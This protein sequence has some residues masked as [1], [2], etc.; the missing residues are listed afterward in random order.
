MKRVADIWNASCLRPSTPYQSRAATDNLLPISLYQFMWCCTRLIGIIPWYNTTTDR[1]SNRQT[2]NSKSPTSLSANPHF[3]QIASNSFYGGSIFIVF[4]PL[5]NFLHNKGYTVLVPT[6]YSPNNHSNSA[7]SW[8]LINPHLLPF[9]HSDQTSPSLPS[10][11][12]RQT[13]NQELITSIAC[14]RSTT[15]NECLQ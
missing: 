6:S 4:H 14:S 9:P 7:S 2:P 15:N 3:S 13:V 11:L 12:K 8:T 5:Y 10:L 1:D